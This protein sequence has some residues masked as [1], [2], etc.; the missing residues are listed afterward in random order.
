MVTIV[1]VVGS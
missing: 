1:I